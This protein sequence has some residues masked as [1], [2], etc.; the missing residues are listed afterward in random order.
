[1]EDERG[2][3]AVVRLGKEEEEDCVCDLV[4]DGMIN[5]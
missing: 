4:N 1:M 3:S 2:N 5:C